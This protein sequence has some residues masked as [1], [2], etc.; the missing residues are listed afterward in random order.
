VLVD[1]LLAHPEA[2]AGADRTFGR[3]ERLEDMLPRAG[4]NAFPVVSYC[5]PDPAMAVV[6]G[7][8]RG[9]PQLDRAVRIDSVQTVGQEIGLKTV[10]ISSQFSRAVCIFT[11]MPTERHHYA[12]L[13]RY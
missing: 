3:E 1:N 13:P 6:K 10:P 4:A 9:H 11:S 2:K 5:Y 8:A 12:G 7:C